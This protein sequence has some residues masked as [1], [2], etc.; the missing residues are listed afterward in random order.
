MYKGIFWICRDAT[1]AWK[2][3]AVKAPCGRDGTALFPVRYS[4]KSGENFNHKAEW[5][6][7][8]REITG[9]RPYNYFPRGRVEIRKGW[10]T[11]YVPPS[12]FRED[13]L[14]A[15]FQE[16][17]LNRE[18]T[19]RSVCVKADGSAHYQFQAEEAL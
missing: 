10:I 17:G 4:S 7:L 3:L 14:S 5:G 8:R 2:L 19:G 16:F 9:G 12:L 13:A 15:I 18:A 6:R 11:V 1:G